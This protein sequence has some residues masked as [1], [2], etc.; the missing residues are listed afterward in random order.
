LAQPPQS[1]EE[2]PAS[3]GAMVTMVGLAVRYL[4]MISSSV[5]LKP[6]SRA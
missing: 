6:L 5:P 3:D 1:L 2:K 4:A